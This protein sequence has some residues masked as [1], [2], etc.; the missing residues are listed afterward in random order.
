MA[1]VSG[2]ETFL[3]VAEEGEHRLSCPL[4]VRA[5]EDGF[6]ELVSPYG[7]GGMVAVCPA[8]DL[9]R[10]RAGWIEFARASGFVTAYIMQ[11]P[12]LRLAH[13]TWSPDLQEHHSLNLID[14]TAAIE[15]LWRSMHKTHRYEIRRLEN[16]PTVELIGG[17]PRLEQALLEL[18]PQT[19]ARVGASKVY[20]FSSAVLERLAR[21]S[22]SLLLG[23]DDGTGIQA[24][25]LFLHT[26]SAADYFLNASSPGGRKYTRLLVWSS[27]KALKEASV[28]GLNLGGGVKPGDSLDR[29]KRRFGGRMVVGHVLKQ[30]FDLE[31]YDYLCRRYC[32]SDPAETNYFPP[33][34]TND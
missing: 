27:I 14:L 4:S 25:T 17:G 10:F 34:W 24:I 30:I 26:P 32:R 29:F 20:H 8:S 3:Y 16:D 2:L 22:G 12:M 28:V 5:K 7:F 23:V 19:V 21:A 11:H 33:Y 15:D 31:K 13:R 18:Y 6:P 1:E 9:R